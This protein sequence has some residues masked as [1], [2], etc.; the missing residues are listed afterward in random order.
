MDVFTF[1]T[2]A[3]KAVVGRPTRPRITVLVLGGGERS[4]RPRWGARRVSRRPAAPRVSGI[5]I[6]PR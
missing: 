5:I 4:E 2:E 3:Q 6:E 1:L